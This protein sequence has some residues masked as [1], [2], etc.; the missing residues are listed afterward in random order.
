MIM[1]TMMI[2]R[3]IVVTKQ[4]QQSR[5]PFYNY[6]HFFLLSFLPS[7]FL[8]SLPSFPLYVYYKT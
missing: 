7:F 4:A 2:R 1:M 5:A 8:S 6:I 3:F